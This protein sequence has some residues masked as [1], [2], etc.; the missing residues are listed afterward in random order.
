MTV[1]TKSAAFY[2][3]L[4]SWKDYQGEVEK[5]TA[6]IRSCVPDARTLLDVACGTGRDLE[7]LSDGY[8][9]EGLDLDAQLLAS[10]A[11]A[12]RA[13]PSTPVTCVTSSL[14]DDSTWSPVCCLP[15]SRPR[16]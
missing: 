10:P 8:R 2:D 14:V 5:L 4:Y 13:F 3:A 12:F 1:F 6:V 15:G 11:N 7:L 9:V 16:C